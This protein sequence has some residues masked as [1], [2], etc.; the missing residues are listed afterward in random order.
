MPDP[1]EVAQNQSKGPSRSHARRVTCGIP[2]DMVEWMDSHKVRGYKRID[3]VAAGLALVYLL[4]H[5]GEIPDWF[6]KYKFKPWDGDSLA[7]DCPSRS[8]SRPRKKIKKKIA[9]KPAAP[10]PSPGKSLSHADFEGEFFD[11]DE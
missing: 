2:A 4:E 5:H 11:W 10:S 1:I 8:R 6:D 9:N 3:I 7:D